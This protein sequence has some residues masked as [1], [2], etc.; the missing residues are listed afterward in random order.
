MKVS[1]ILIAGVLALSATAA[2]ASTVLFPT[3]GDVNF[4]VSSSFV[5]AGYSLAIFDDSEA[6]SPGGAIV[7][8][9][10][11]LDVVMQGPFFTFAGP[12]YGG[13]INFA[14][15][16]GP[17]GAYQASNDAS[18]VFNFTGPNDNFIVGI[19][20]DNGASWYADIGSSPGP[21]NSQ[22]LSFAVENGTFVVDVGK[23]PA[24]PVPA[25]VWLF[26]SGLLG[27]VGIARRR[28]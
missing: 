19:S 11:S 23:V 13:I 16:V 9:T 25:A 15:A 6:V 26:G 8:S 21:A 28:A 10:G 5:T 18:T 4:Y 27:M 7:S 12:A 22:Q 1:K 14:G 17:G 3:D 2:S 24:V 20:T